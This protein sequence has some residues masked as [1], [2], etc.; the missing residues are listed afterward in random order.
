MSTN[1]NIST[2][3]IPKYYAVGNVWYGDAKDGKVI[4]PFATKADVIKE[5]ELYESDSNWYMSSWNKL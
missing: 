4:G 3:E 2:F 1:D 5:V